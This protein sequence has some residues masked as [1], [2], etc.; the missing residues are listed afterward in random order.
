M[1]T[2]VDLSKPKY[3]ERQELGARILHTL[4]VE[5]KYPRSKRS[6]CYMAELN[7][8]NSFREGNGR[9][10]REFMQRL[11]LRNGY[12]VDWGAVLVDEL[13]QAMVDSI[14]ETARLD[15]VLNKCLQKADELNCAVYYTTVESSILFVSAKN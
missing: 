4:F 12:E 9:A 6:A 3:T 2:V 8:I 10:T 14:Y 11:F 5:S 15:D 13:L 7:Y 1:N